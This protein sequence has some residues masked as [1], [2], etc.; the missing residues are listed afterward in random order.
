MKLAVLG[1]TG[2]TGAL[3]V[4]RALDQGHDLTVLVRDP[5]KL[6]L[7]H[8]RLTIVQGEAMKPADVAKVM[9][10]AD[11]VVSA[12]G[13]TKQL[14]EV[15]SAAT[16]GVLAAGV[17]RYVVVSGAGL[18]APG[19]T[20]NFPNKVI[21]KLIGWFSPAMV[22]DKALELS[23]LQQSD[24][25]WTLVRPPRL[26][27]DAPTGHSRVALTSPP[28]TSLTRGDLA[29]FLLTCATEGRHV[30]EAPFIAN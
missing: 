5:K 14:V 20:K 18:D 6:P 11:A 9:E 16:R 10:G 24:C 22:K 3:F 7:T 23:L 12:L 26:V 21:S 1:A 25:A 2:R 30:R 29:E 19:D 17:K 15:C 13:P 4:Q 28:G 8:S 27:D